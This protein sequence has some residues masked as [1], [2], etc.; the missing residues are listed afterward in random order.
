MATL[1]LRANGNFRLHLGATAISNL[2]DGISTLALPW[3][4]TLLTRDPLLL[5]VMTM[6]GR[7]PWLVLALP[8]GVWTDRAD[9]RQLMV[10]ADAASAI[11]T[12]G[13]LTL[14][15]S[16]PGLT[17]PEAAPFW[18]I[19]VLAG[20]SFMLG[21]AEVVRDNA[22]QTLL[23]Q[24]VAH[25]DLERA[26]GLAWSAEQVMNQF[27]GPPLAGVLI[28]LGT[29]LPFGVDAAS[30]AISAILV[31]LMILPR[32]A[33]QPIAP[34]WAA[35]AE[36]WRWIAAHRTI[37]TLAIMLAL[38]NAAYTATLTVQVLYV[39]EIV[40]LSAPQY[41]LLLTVGAAGGVI[42]GIIAPVIARRIGARRGLCL[43]LAVFAINPALIAVSRGVLPVAGALFIGAA[44]SMLWNVITVSY[45][46]RAIPAA[47][48][49][50]VNSIYRFFGWGSMPLGALAG[51]A[52]VSL[53]Q[54]PLGRDV[55]LRL[56]F[57]ASSGLCLALLV[58]AL[59]RLRLA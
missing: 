50:R 29:A 46:Q 15:F 47:I 5:G 36:G 31:S 21:L 19:M 51:G 8:A 44:A 26:N 23:P 9:R 35:M 27:I 24:I 45:R 14:V 2:G 42:G 56:P 38:I 10:R 54:D 52:I 59:A 11:L 22:A 32:P 7:L 25:E 49:G 28:A 53:A 3:L 18:P 48:L 13:I 30:F 4:V 1:P 39:Q 17:P 43:A 34:F 37:L 20:L 41:G 6:A 33:L 57:A 55:A 16:L 58:F 40:G 12:C